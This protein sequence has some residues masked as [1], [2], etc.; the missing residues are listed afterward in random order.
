VV[1]IDAPGLELVAISIHAHTALALE[2]TK[3]TYWHG[4]S[5]LGFQNRPVLY[6]MDA[7]ARA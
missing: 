6:L 4:I 2:E 3:R 1:S 7:N 5:H